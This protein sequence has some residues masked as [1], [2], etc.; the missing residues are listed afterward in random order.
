MTGAPV[1]V[2]HLCA[3]N[4]YGGVE[5]I[6]VECARS[7]ALCRELEP[8]FGVCFAGRLEEEIESAGARCVRL[9]AVRFSRPQ[10]VWRARR[11]LA[12]LLVA[13]PPDTVICHSSWMFALAAPVVR[14][15]SAQLAVWIHDCVSGQP[16][17]ERWARRTA[18]DVVIA[19]SRFTAATV[20]ALFDGVRSEVVYAPVA[21]G[22]PDA[23]FDRKRFRAAMGAADADVVIL[24]AS[25]F[26]EW[27]GHRLLA[28]A[29]SR[30]TGEWRVWIA[31][32]PQREHE[33]AYLESLE[34]HL[35]ASGVQERV[36]F[37]GDRRDI[38]S[39]MRA[40]DIHCQP[41]TAP[42]PFGLA[43]VEALYAGLPVVTTAMGGACE[44]VTADCGVLVPPGDVQAL[45]NALQRLI[46]DPGERR[47][48]GS[49][50]PARAAA[51]CDPAEQ[52][53]TLRRV[54]ARPQMAAASSR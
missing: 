45:A 2:L 6:V 46:A 54:A 12:D 27:K 44:I 3:G 16:W 53:A 36:R 8:V 39:V 49:A 13:E 17:A 52:L 30:L 40:A 1:R 50:G 47:R 9:G 33:R 19:N 28:D 15:T 35:A 25:R 23:A 34:R 31:G 24:I 7:R 14:R 20:P 41:N 48:L 38:A 10:T 5:R 51:L 4:L 21:A 43:F 22:A 32:A 42:E 18:P 37:I 26:E 29:V 11:R